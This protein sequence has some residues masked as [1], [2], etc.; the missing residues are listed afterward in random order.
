LYGVV[1]PVDSPDLGAPAAGKGTVW[2]PRQNLGILHDG[3]L[4][5]VIDPVEQVA[6]LAIP[7]G[8]TWR[9]IY[10]DTPA[11]LAPKL[12]LADDRGLAGAGLWALGYDRGLPG[13]RELIGDFRA[14]RLG[15][16]GTAASAGP[17]VP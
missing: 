1:W 9:A 15:G 14:G 8:A 4:Q 13:Y 3:T 10:Y 12:V 2:I 17:A 16:S 7:D 11:T 5:P 6:F